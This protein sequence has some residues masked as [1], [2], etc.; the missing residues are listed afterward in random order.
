MLQHSWVILLLPLVGTAVISILGR[1]LSKLATALVACGVVGLA[2]LG[3]VVAAVQLEGLPPR[4]QA[5]QEVL[6]RWIVSGPLHISFGLLVDPIS[7]LFMLVI[8]GVGFLIHVYSVGYMGED[9]NFR[10]YFAYLNLFIFTMLLLVMANNFLWLLV[11]WG[12]VGLASYL[13]IGFWYERP[14]AVAAAIKAFVMNVIGDVGIFLAIFL[15]YLSFHSVSYNRVFH[16]AYTHPAAAGV[17]TAITL[18][19]LLGAVAKSA[20]LPLH[21]W[22][23]DAMEG[24][25]PVSALIHAATMVTAGVYLVARCYPLYHLSP[26]GATA[27]AVV[28]G[29]SALLAATIG[30]AQTDIK[31]ALAASTMSQ[32]G[33]MIMA[34]GLGMYAAGLFHFLTHAFF[35]ALLFMAAG[36]IIHALGGEQD[37]RKMGGL[38]KRLPVTYW[39]FLAGTLAISGIPGF[40]G[41]FSKDE[42]LGQALN[43]GHVVLW[44]VGVAAAFLTAFYMFRMFFL[45]FSGSYRGE[46]H[47][48]GEAPRVMLVPTVILAVLAVVGGY[49]VLPGV[50]DLIGNFL[51]PAFSHWHGGAGA[52]GNPHHVNWLSMG[53]SVLL[54]LAG[55]GVAYQVYHRRAWQPAPWP[56]LSQL[57]YRKYYFDELYDAV[58]V[59]PAVRLGAVF[60]AVADRLVID[61]GVMGLARGVRTLGNGLVFLQSGYVRRYA[62]TIALGA[63]AILAYY[64]FWA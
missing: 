49:L 63:A 10:L 64:V 55:F 6:F 41:F 42:L 34:V 1:Y 44:A 52:V 53:V 13:L 27:V 23:F 35:K 48:H 28:G 26:T 5:V 32:I 47:P 19:L 8:T 3:T 58:F 4:L 14:S 18:L 62:L 57:L 25:T 21:T 51:A 17:M 38:A 15:I 39:S 37:L 46:V 50:W 24:P 20:Q 59:R 16:L 56:F 40:S 30:T 7:L 9:K 29:A 54:A 31:R 61:G 45:A 2:F 60:G 36:N 33:Y 11:G 43:R 22:L 12:G